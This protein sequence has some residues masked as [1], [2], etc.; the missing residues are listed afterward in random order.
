[1]NLVYV[2]TVLEDLLTE[3]AGV[4][5]NNKPCYLRTT[6][7]TAPHGRLH[8]GIDRD[9]NDT[10]KRRRY[11][12]TIASAPLGIVRVSIYINTINCDFITTNQ[13]RD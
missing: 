6:I 13:H 10:P 5:E 1:M 12:I 3:E 11:Y 8:A 7:A 4:T 2:Y 9:L